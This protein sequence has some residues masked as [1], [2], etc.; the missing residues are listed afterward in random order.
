MK[1]AAELHIPDHRGMVIAVDLFGLLFTAA[2][3]VV[4]WILLSGKKVE[5]AC[6]K[7]I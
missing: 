6:G 7:V 1:T 2:L 4:V 5:T 3:P